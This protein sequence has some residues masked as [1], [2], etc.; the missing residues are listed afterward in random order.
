MR[1]VGQLIGAEKRTVT[2]SSVF[3][4]DRVGIELELER[5]IDRPELV[6]WNVTE[7]GS[8]RNSGAEFVLRDGYGGMELEQAIDELFEWISRG[9]WDANWRC[10]THFHVDMQDFT[11][12]Q[13]AKFILL[14]TSRESLMFEM[15]D[16]NRKNSNFCVPVAS[17]VP[18]YKRLMCNFRS[19]MHSTN[20]GQKYTALNVLPLVTQGT[21]EYR[22]AGPIT[23]K[24]Q[25]THM[26]QTLQGMKG[27]VRD[28]GEAS[29]EEFLNSVVHEYSPDVANAY[30]LLK[31]YVA[32]PPQQQEWTAA[33]PTGQV[34]TE[35]D[36]NTMIASLQSEG[37]PIAKELAFAAIMRSS[38][39][40]LSPVSSSSGCMLYNTINRS[41]AYWES[42]RATHLTN[43]L[44]HSAV[45][46][47]LTGLLGTPRTTMEELWMRYHNLTV[48]TK[49]RASWPWRKP[50]QPTMTCKE[51]RESGREVIEY[52]WDVDKA[53][54]RSWCDARN[55]LAYRGKVIPLRIDEMWWC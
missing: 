55:I 19:I 2:P 14:F 39:C 34:Q 47:V 8:L 32:G 37:S 3:S 13:V 48:R 23:N 15:S 11:L 50:L 26:V 33:R 38:H 52:I 7:D 22:G 27:L 16:P 41:H 53:K 43:G 40:V 49:N 29:A 28:S 36:F 31:S 4:N 24:M 20:L 45:S 30:S 10:S 6:F 18:F 42:I 17:A 46:R 44:S 25:M 12:D 21:L 1:T 51:L 35:T 9:T 5:V 54:Y